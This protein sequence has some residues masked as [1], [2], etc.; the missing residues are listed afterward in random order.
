MYNPQ[1]RLEIPA[2]LFVFASM[3]AFFP[4]R[5]V[6]AN[7]DMD[8]QFAL[9]TVGCLPSWD[10][11][12]GVF[13]EYVAEAY[14]DYFGRQ[15]RFVQQNL[16]KA[17]P[18]LTDSKIPYNKIIEDPAILSQLAR[19][20]HSQ[21]IIRTKVMKEGAQYR[22]NLA[23]LHA[24][25]MDML[26]SDEFTLKEAEGGGGFSQD[27]IRKSLQ[28]SLDRLIGR[29]P[30]LGSV[31]GR[32]RNSITV[33]VGKAADIKPGDTLVIGTLEEVK[34]HPLLNEMVDWRISPTGKVT[35]QQVEDN[36]AFCKLIEEQPQHPIGRYQKIIQIIGS[37]VAQD[38]TGDSKAQSSNVATGGDALEENEPLRPTLGWLSGSL[39]IGG[40][41]RDFSNSNTVAKTGGGL[42]LGS[43]VD[44]QLWLTSDWFAEV[45][46][47]QALWRYSQ[48]DI[49]S[50]N[51]TLSE[52]SGSASDL[53]VASGYS[54][55]VGSSPF[56]PKAWAKLGYHR[57]AYTL[58]I[59]ANENLA[60]ATFKSLYLGIGGEL[61]LRS[62]L[63]AMMDLRFGFLPS[64]EETG[65]KSGSVKSASDV[66]FFLGASYRYNAWMTFR[67]GIEIMANTAN[68]ASSSLSEKIIT[69]AP[70]F[71][72][73]F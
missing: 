60:P 25:K 59:L 47:G 44:G 52:I 39:W 14:R 22:F 7:P 46:Y 66:Q 63:S 12:D 3:M 17:E 65:G 2:V 29:V 31:T 70:S 67:G 9:E 48:K 55:I 11:I 40:F 72:Y 28:A 56:G 35:V 64:G 32:D 54:F 5:T 49:A 71:L 23:W 18:V 43:R 27:E 37:P 33:N 41:S 69:F 51:T 57:I 21:T 58:P 4:S 45:G 24:P 30:F 6:F 8:R 68:F 1:R 20:S 36:L 19:V 15:S 50:G 34:K 42:V 38:A 62:N 13:S 53:S 26:A 61:P 73:Y 10:N 16:S